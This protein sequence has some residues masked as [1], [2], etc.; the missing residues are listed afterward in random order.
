MAPQ[1]GVR[2]FPINLRPVLGIEKSRSTKGMG[3]LAKGSLRMYRATG[4]TV[5]R[6]K[7]NMAL[8]WLME[9]HSQ[10]VQRR[11]VGEYCD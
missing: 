7:T 8:E 2:R 4:N 9:N 5:W 6:D 10:E 1:Q 3:L 11:L